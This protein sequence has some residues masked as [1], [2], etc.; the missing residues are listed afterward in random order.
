[1]PCCA[2][3]RTRITRPAHFATNDSRQARSFAVDASVAHAPIIVA[4]RAGVAVSSC[5]I[6][7]AVAYVASI[8]AC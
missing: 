4:S 7:L 3:N 5:A 1:M 2:T 8:W 6:A